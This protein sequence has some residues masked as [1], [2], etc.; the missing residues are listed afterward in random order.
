L[1]IATFDTK[2]AAHP[3]S[4]VRVLSVP[5]GPRFVVGDGDAYSVEGTLPEYP[6]RGGTR[7]VAEV[8]GVMAP[9]ICSQWILAVTRYSAIHPDRWPRFRPGYVS[10]GL[11]ASPALPVCR[12]AAL[13]H[14]GQVSDAD[15]KFGQ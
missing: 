9:V 10:N 2:V 5:Y 11:Q 6:D 13:G 8:V 3:D 4:S 12:S 14:A 7:C 1:R 15:M